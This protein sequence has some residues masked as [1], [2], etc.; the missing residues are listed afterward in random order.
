MGGSA[1]VNAGG[2]DRRRLLVVLAAVV[3]T[4]TLLLLG[5]GYAVYV[6]L[7]SAT[8]TA[9]PLQAVTAA[10]ATA[11]PASV[12]KS[13][14]LSGP[15]SASPRTGRARRPAPGAGELGAQAP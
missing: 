13:R 11:N 7:T 6:A 8:G 10:P 2:W 3:A 12:M 1:D 4:A 14:R 9:K 5:L 15:L